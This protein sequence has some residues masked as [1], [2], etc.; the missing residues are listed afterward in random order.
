MCILQPQAY[1]PLTQTPFDSAQDS[2]FAPAKPFK[3][4]PIFDN[5]NSTVFT[6]LLAAQSF[7]SLHFSIYDSRFSTI[8]SP[9]VKNLRTTADIR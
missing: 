8:F 5:R 3:Q 4:L 6:R 2:K 9:L 1:C 7:L